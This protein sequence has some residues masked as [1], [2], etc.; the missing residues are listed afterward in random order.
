MSHK[1]NNELIELEREIDLEKDK[2]SKG[3]AKTIILLTD[4]IID[5]S[6][7]EK[8]EINYFGEIY[9]F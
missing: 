2:L 8:D 6:K 7:T 3:I 1:K 5:T 4:L 9:L